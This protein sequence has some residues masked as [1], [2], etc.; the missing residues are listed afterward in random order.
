MSVLFRP[1]SESSTRRRNG[2]FSRSIL[3]P[4]SASTARRSEFARQHRREHAEGAADPELRDEVEADQREAAHRDR[5]RQAGEEHGAPGGRARLG[6][7]VARRE[8]VVQQLSEAGDDEERVVDPDTEPDHRDE[9]RRDR[10]DVGQAR[11]DEE[12]EER[13]GER[14]DRQEDRDHHRHEGAEDDEQD[15]D[16]REQAEP[17]LGS[18][19]DGRELRVAVVLDGDAGRLDRLAHGLLHGDDLLAVLGLDRLRELRL[20]VGDAAVV[21]DRLLAERVADL[22]DAGLVGG[23]RELVGLEAGDRLL[24]RRAALGRVEPLALGRREDDVQDGALLLRELGLDQVGRLLRVRARDLEHV[25]ERPADRPD[26][27]DQERD[28]AEPAE[29]DAP[30]MRGAGS[31]PACERAGG[32]TLVR[33]AT[34]RPESVRHAECLLGAD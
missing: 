28:D 22:L 4:R 8:A 29:D 34:L 12:Q 16:R 24:D 13:R 1:A 10:V 3:C 6:G 27:D 9:D 26:E 33:F 20:G 5:D 11:E 15:D 23:R 17:L 32:L 2:T 31:R 25:L 18:L 19:L 30:G 7:G 14:R 21:R